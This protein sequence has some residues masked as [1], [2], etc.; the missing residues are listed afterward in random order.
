M[1]SH[2]SMWILPV[3]CLLTVDLCVPGENGRKNFISE[4]INGVFLIHVYSFPFNLGLGSVSFFSFCS[5]S[6]WLVASVL[7]VFRCVYFDWRI[8]FSACRD[9]LPRSMSQQITLFRKNQ[10][11]FYQTFY[12]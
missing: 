5:H 9:Q 4:I 12:Y 1:R 3:S 11:S 7:I 6:V 10:K 8:E 2:P